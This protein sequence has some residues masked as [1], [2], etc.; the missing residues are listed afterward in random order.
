V[1]KI[2]DWFGCHDRE[3]WPLPYTGCPK[4]PG[5]SAAFFERP[6]LEE[7]YPI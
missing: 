7:S 3:V 5:Q 4:N 6:L 2:N 1:L